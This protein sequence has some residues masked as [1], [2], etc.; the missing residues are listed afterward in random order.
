MSVEAVAERIW[1]AYDSDHDG[2][3]NQEEAKAFF[4]ELHSKR[5]DLNLT[6][7]EEWFKSIDTNGDGAISKEEMIEYLKSINFTD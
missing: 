2:N 3:I 7:V 6:S 4:E 5:P 1:T